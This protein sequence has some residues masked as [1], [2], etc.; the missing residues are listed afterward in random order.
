MIC[1]TNNITIDCLPS[2]VDQTS[3]E[4][5]DFHVESFHA[6]EAFK[7]W[8]EVWLQDKALF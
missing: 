8:S 3:V 1:N 7:D 4:I 2:L 5:R 6:R